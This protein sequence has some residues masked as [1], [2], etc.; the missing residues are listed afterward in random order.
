LADN[1]MDF[2][3]LR[4]LILETAQKVQDHLPA[5]VQTGPAIRNDQQTMTTHLGMLDD[6]PALKMIYELLSQEIIKNDNDKATG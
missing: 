5:E 2:A 3:L 4:P 6:E 1:Q